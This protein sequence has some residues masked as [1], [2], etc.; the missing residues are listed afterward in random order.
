MD[1]GVFFKNYSTLYL[2]FSA[3]SIEHSEVYEIH[4]WDFIAISDESLKHRNIIKILLPSMAAGLLLVAF[5]LC[6]RYCNCLLFLWTFCL[7]PFF[8][9]PQAEVEMV[10]TRA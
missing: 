4:S 2:G 3:F 9:V 5:V 6:I 1:L 7:G 10:G 8:Q